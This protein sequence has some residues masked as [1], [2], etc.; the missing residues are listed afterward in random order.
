MIGVRAVR[1]HAACRVGIAVDF[2]VAVHRGGVSGQINGFPLQ[3]DTC[4][5]LDY[6]ALDTAFD[7]QRM[8]RAVIAELC[9]IRVFR[10]PDVLSLNGGLSTSEY[11][12]PRMTPSSPLASR[13]TSTCS[14]RQGASNPCYPGYCAA[15]R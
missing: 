1:E 4:R 2:K 3:A 5:N 15:A 7:R 10:A 8:G 12:A 13:S 6:Y 11:T 14:P 9:T